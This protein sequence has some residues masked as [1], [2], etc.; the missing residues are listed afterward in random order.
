MGKQTPKIHTHIA[1]K[2]NEKYKYV[3]ELN[4]YIN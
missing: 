4:G 2:I 3:H 1:Q